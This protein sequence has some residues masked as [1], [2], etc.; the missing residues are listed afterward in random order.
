MALSSL[1]TV[2]GIAERSEAT[3]GL[4]NSRLSDINANLNALRADLF[5]SA[6]AVFNIE[7]YSALTSASAAVNRVSIQSAIK[8][9]ADAGGGIVYVPPG[10]YSV[11]SYLQI[12]GPNVRILGVPNKSVISWSSFGT[13]ARSFG[14]SATINGGIVADMDNTHIEGLVLTGPR[15]A[16]TYTASDAL[17]SSV[18]SS[19]ASRVENIS[20]RRCELSRSGAYGIYTQWLSRVVVE[21][22]NYIHDVGYNG[23]AFL[24]CDNVRFVGNNVK[25][26]QPGT[27]GNM[28]G[29]SIDHDSSG[30]SSDASAGS[31]FQA[32]P[33]TERAYVAFNEIEDVNW[34]GIDCHG[35][36]E[37]QIVHNRVF[38]TKYGIS[39][40]GGSGS[41]SSFAGYNNIVA[42][43]VVDGRKSDG[44]VSGRENTGY[45][46]NVGGGLSTTTRHQNIRVIGNTLINK[47]PVADNA[48]AVILAE[49]TRGLL[50]DGNILQKWGGVGIGIGNAENV[51]IA[52]NQFLELS[53]ATDSVA[54]AIFTSVA[55]PTQLVV[56]GNSMSSNGGTAGRTGLNAASLT[57]RPMLGNNDFRVAT[58]AATSLPAEGFQNGADAPAILVVSTAST[59]PTLAGITTPHVVIKCTQAS[60]FTF[61]NIVGAVEGQLVTIM[62]TV[63]NNLGLT[64]DNAV[65][66]SGAEWTGGQY[67]TISLR[68]LSPLWYEVGRAVNS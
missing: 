55:L 18:G 19:S 26:V 54:A 43:N 57:S 65:L 67:D 27:S 41:A 37:V 23:C 59:I 21:D 33:F 8:A 7:A 16:N 17:I 58:V 42:F 20:V 29:V 32:N 39:C 4:W 5:Q 38:N 60:N 40:P 64:R 46:I 35:A 61:T 28:Y 63:N 14:F 53:I 10:I 56:T 48:S 51:V 22:S 24:S 36:Y 52:N 25:T 15:A 50:V 13:F 31:K 6:G 3:P 47:G 62:Q 45:G 49:Y 1:S 9:A 66:G 30:Y 11:N 44:S 68:F 2:A 34:E 12:T